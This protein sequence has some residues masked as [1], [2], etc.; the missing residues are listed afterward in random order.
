MGSFYGTG[1]KRIII[2][3]VTV[4][5]MGIMSWFLLPHLLHGEGGWRDEHLLLVRIKSLENDKAG[6]EHFPLYV[7]SETHKG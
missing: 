2:P 5:L 6:F 1:R 3:F 7:S 4:L